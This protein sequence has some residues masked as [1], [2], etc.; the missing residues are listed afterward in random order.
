MIFIKRIL[1]SVFVSLRLS[2]ST[3]NW[4]HE[5]GLTGLHTACPARDGRLRIFHILGECKASSEIVDKIKVKYFFVNM[6][7]EEA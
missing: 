2:F 5:V 1:L 7:Y 3:A 4:I 6:L